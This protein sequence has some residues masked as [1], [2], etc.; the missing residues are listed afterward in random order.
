MGFWGFGVLGEIKLLDDEL[1]IDCNKHC[2]L[3]KRVVCGV[4][5][6]T[7]LNECIAVCKYQVSKAYD[8][9]C[10]TNRRCDC[11]SLNNPVCG[12]NEVTY[13][14]ECYLNCIGVSKARNGSCRDILN[15]GCRCS[16]IKNE[17]C[18]IDRVTYFNKCYALCAKMEFVVQGR[19]EEIPTK[20]EFVNMTV[21]SDEIREVQAQSRNPR[22]IEDEIVS[23]SDRSKTSIDRQNV[24]KKKDV[25]VPVK[26]NREVSQCECDSVIDE[27]CGV[28]GKVY[29][30]ECLAGCQGIQTQNMVNC[31]SNNEPCVCSRA[32]KQVC[33][34]NG[35]T[36]RNICY[37]S[38]EGVSVVFEGQCSGNNNK[39]EMQELNECGCNSR[40]NPICDRNGKQYTN[41]CLALC[42][43]VK[44]KDLVDCVYNDGSKGNKI[45]LDEIRALDR[46]SF[47]NVIERENRS[48]ESSIIVKKNNIYKYKKNCLC[49]DS[50]MPVCGET[51][52][53]YKNLCF[54]FCYG[55]IFKSAGECQ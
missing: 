24:L 40:F 20:D 31:K 26:R 46:D 3:E 45:I 42:L 34:E 17:V 39:V 52:S 51:G 16:K 48:N 28:D 41:L 11:P 44:A 10:V 50:F 21:E 8:G 30:N 53:T 29:T 2:S 38:C 54:M 14:N 12:V 6:M 25:I 27:V 35:R 22:L 4:D 37:A 23:V 19:C 55:D 49:N 33:G 47:E 18:G 36:Y 43:G 32:I 13:L 15:S 1:D 7:Y 5:N 9:L